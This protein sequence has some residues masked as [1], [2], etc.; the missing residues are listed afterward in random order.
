MKK[1]SAK[2]QILVLAVQ[3]LEVTMSRH[4]YEIESR[5]AAVGGG[6]AVQRLS[7]VFG[8]PRRLRYV[9]GEGRDDPDEMFILAVRHRLQDLGTSFLDISC[10]ERLLAGGGC[11]GSLV[12]SPR[13]INSRSAEAKAFL[14]SS[15][16]RQ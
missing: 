13:R 4:R 5:P 14:R 10:D 6:C 2:G 1:D 11:H 8:I 9:C 7:S 3:G 16:L 15:G 12:V